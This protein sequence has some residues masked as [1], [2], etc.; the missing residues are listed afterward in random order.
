MQVGGCGAGR[1]RLGRVLLCLPKLGHRSGQGDE[2]GHERDSH[3]RGVAGQIPGQRDHPRS[4][5]QLVVMAPQ[6]GFAQVMAAEGEVVA[7]MSCSLSLVVPVAG[8]WFVVCPAPE[9]KAGAIG[10]ESNW[11]ARA[12][13]MFSSGQKKSAGAAGTEGCGPRPGKDLGCPERAQREPGCAPGRACETEQAG[14]RRGPAT[15]NQAEDGR[16]GRDRRRQCHRA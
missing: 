9:R 11:P 3:Q 1:C 8:S 5:A 13:K 15:G 4:S 10:R 12:A 6:E 2:L 14:I 7:S 16:H